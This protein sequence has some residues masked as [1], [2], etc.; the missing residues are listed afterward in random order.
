M[1]EFKDY[2]YRSL[3]HMTEILERLDQER[4]F[5]EEGL[6]RSEKIAQNH[7]KRI[8]KLEQVMVA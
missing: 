2:V 1:V 3:D 5:T 7:E 4:L 8:T 6:R